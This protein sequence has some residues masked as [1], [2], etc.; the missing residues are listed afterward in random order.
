MDVVKKFQ[1]ATS[2]DYFKIGS[3]KLDRKYPIIHAERIFTESGPAVLLSIKE[4]P[5]NILK[6]LMPKRYS[7]VISGENVESI[8][9]QKVS[10]NLIYKGMCEKSKCHLAVE[11]DRKRIGFFSVLKHLKSI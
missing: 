10:L 9:S 8:N 5:Y 7:A 1:E 11:E 6:V 2:S 3:L 4:L